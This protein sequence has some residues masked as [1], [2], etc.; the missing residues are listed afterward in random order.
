MTLALT[1]EEVCEDETGSDKEYA[2]VAYSKPK[3]E[4]E[5][6]CLARYKDT[7][8]T[9]VQVSLLISNITHP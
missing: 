1:W 7:D 6:R 4:Q 8:I 5:E 3:E 2:R 9:Y